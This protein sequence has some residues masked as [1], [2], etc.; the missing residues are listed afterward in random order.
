MERA[1]VIDRLLITA[2]LVFFGIVC[3]Y[4]LK[5]RVLDK[6]LRVAG[7]FGK[8]IPTRMFSKRSAEVVQEVIS[9]ATETF[10]TPTATMA[11][12]SSL[13]TAVTAAAST[14]SCSSVVSS[15]S[16]A[17]QLTPTSITRVQSEFCS[18]SSYTAEP[19]VASATLEIQEEPMHKPEPAHVLDE[20]EPAPPAEPSL[21]QRLLQTYETQ[22]APMAVETA[23][24]ST[25]EPE[26]H[27]LSSLRGVATE[28]TSEDTLAAEVGEE[29]TSVTLETALDSSS[30]S[31]AITTSASSEAEILASLATAH[32]VVDDVEEGDILPPEHLSQIKDKLVD[33]G[34]L[35]AEDDDEEEEVETD[36]VEADAVQETVAPTQERTHD[37]L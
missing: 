24:A 33:R 28:K 21:D 2:A 3:L 8:L 18:A 36:S 7:V 37:E 17:S 23:D 25:P 10:S 31:L 32:P 5:R 20:P 22:D 27:P 30:S 12:L 19:I 9:T 13:A 26:P 6:G 4:I 15:S 35:E 16:I 1:D 11:A 14:V 34:H 29:E